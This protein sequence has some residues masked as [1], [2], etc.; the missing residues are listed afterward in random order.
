MR[1]PGRLP[2]LAL[3]V[4]LAA[5]PGHAQDAEL[6]ESASEWECPHPKGW[7]PSPEELQATLQAHGEWFDEEG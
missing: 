6:F 2:T 5:A 1:T 3:L 4:A 7:R